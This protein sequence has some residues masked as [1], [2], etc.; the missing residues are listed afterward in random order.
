MVSEGPGWGNS[1][2]Y[3]CFFSGKEKLYIGQV[4]DFG[5]TWAI[6]EHIGE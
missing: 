2:E 5:L 4:L 1:G 3:N 6:A